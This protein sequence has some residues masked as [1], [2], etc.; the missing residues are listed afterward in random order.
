MQSDALLTTNHPK[1]TK[2]GREL[3]MMILSADA[4]LPSGEG[5]DKAISRRDFVNIYNGDVRLRWGMHLFQNTLWKSFRYLQR[6]DVRGDEEER[7]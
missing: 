6:Y 1:G 3:L 2:L 4:G 5:E 7:A